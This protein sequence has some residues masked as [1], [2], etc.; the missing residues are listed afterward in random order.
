[1]V[2][3]AGVMTRRAVLTI[4]VA[5]GL[6]GLPVG[7]TGVAADPTTT[8][9]AAD[10]PSP[11]NSGVSTPPYGLIA[12]QEYLP[13]N[14]RVFAHGVFENASIA[15]VDVRVNWADLEPSPNQCN[16]QIIDQVFDEATNAS[17][18]IVLSVVP[19]FG[20]PDWVTNNLPP[21]NSSATFDRQYGPR[22]GL[23]G[24]LPI[25]WDQTYLSLW[26]T[27]LQ[28]I[29]DRYENN[30]ALRMVSAA[31][32]TSVSEEMS[33]PDR[34]HDPALPNN[35]SDLDAWSTL[36]YTP[37]KYTGAWNTVF[38]QY[39][40]IFPSQY[41]SLS[42]YPGLPIGNNGKHDESQRASTP[43]R[44]VQAG[45]QIQGRLV[46]QGNGLRSVSG[47]PNVYDLVKASRGSVTTGF[48]MTT[49]ATRNPY[50]EGGL[51]ACPQGPTQTP[52]TC[53]QVLALSL[54]LNNGLAG[55]AEFLEVYQPDVLNP[56]M[57]DV[58][59]TTAAQL[60]H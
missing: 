44:V 7:G 34:I 15:G 22:E 51:D 8:A 10:T 26:F 20:T 54:A 14:D 11:V 36:G 59:Q 30:P 48:Q 58:L 49:S 12:V 4:G 52:S 6:A 3:Y 5:L 46:V 24:A 39:A 31:G 38:Q 55:S 27:F 1:L 42:L 41:I 17:K 43:R 60:P 32:P 19:G 29:A 9:C 13:A 16:W 57:Q 37:D 23:P 18:F 40:Q 53:D 25:P 2:N 50:M 21:G 33:L 28:N 45:A 47:G 35:G 56:A